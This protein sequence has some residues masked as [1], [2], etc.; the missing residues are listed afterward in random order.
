[1]KKSLSEIK[2]NQSEWRKISFAF[3]CLAHNDL[4][5]WEKLPS[6]LKE[7]EVGEICQM[8]I[9]TKDSKYIKQAGEMLAGP[10]W[11]TSLGRTF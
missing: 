6:D 7:S 2:K 8:Y 1:M 5:D 10:H 11:Y 3:Y 4:K 9:E